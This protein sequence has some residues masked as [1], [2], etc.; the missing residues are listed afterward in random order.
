M[1]SLT[2][3]KCTGGN[4]C[5]LNTVTLDGV[6]GD[7][8]YVIWHEG[9]PGRVVYIGQGAPISSRLAAHRNNADIQAYAK[10]GMLRV[11]WAEVSAAQRDAVERHLADKWFP[12]VGDAHPVVQPIAVNS[13][14]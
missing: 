13:P 6:K 8:V 9:N 10:K 5:P 14:F 11:T 7:G 1:V 2:W 4:W 3:I 12:L